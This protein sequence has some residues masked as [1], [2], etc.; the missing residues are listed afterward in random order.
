M[1]S[2]VRTT[3]SR[4]QSFAVVPATVRCDL[5]GGELQAHHE[6][7]LSVAGGRLSCACG[8]CSA[9]FAGGTS[10]RYVRVAR[11]AARLLGFDFSEQEWKALSVPVALACLVYRSACSDSELGELTAI[12]PSPAGVI[13]AS[14]PTMAWRSLCMRHA[15]LRNIS[16]DLQA[17]LVDRTRRPARYF[18]VSLDICF[19]FAGL[20]RAG[21]LAATSASAALDRL[22]EPLLKGEQA[23]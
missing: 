16:P 23:S 17:L 21:R 11:S 12:Y 1:S 3:L 15:E 18:A 4:L 14:L 9:L 10:Q 20:M 2:T 6:H 22:L 8:A 13:E 5:C 19:E 7:L